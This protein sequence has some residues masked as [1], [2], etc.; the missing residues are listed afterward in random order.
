MPVPDSAYA[1]TGHCVASL[2]RYRTLHCRCIQHSLSQ[3][4]T[5]RC[6][7]HFPFLPRGSLC[8]RS[9]LI[10]LAFVNCALDVKHESRKL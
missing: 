3:Y 7:R 8:D 6:T 2:C 4:R 10:S 5:L 9:A 1:S